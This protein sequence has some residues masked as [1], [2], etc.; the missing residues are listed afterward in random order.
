[1]H[2]RCAVATRAWCLNDECIAGLQRHL[3]RA[4]EFFDPAAGALDPVS[5]GRARLTSLEAKR[6]HLAM[7][8]QNHRRHWCQKSDAPFRPITAAMLTKT[9]RTFSDLK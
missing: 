4:A 3:V 9:A 7:I 5:A 6:R 1:M 8:R 2:S